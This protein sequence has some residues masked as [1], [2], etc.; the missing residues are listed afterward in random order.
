M[1]KI[2]EVDILDDDNAIAIP[3]DMGDAGTFQIAAAKE[4]APRDR[5]V[6]S[7]DRKACL[8]FAQIFMQLAHGKFKHFHVHMG[9]DDT[10]MSEGFRIE[11]ND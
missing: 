4:D 11:L 3:F 5:I 1:K 2:L 8:S 9:T 7:L 6:L 10:P